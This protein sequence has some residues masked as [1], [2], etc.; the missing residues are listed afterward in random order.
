MKI[1]SVFVFLAIIALISCTS[2]NET[3][4]ESFSVAEE[5]GLGE[6]LNNIEDPLY[7]EKADDY[8]AILNQCLKDY[9]E[10]VDAN[11]SD[12]LY[13]AEAYKKMRSGI[14][15]G[16]LE[17][18]IFNDEINNILESA[19]FRIYSES[20]PVRILIHKDILK[21]YPEKK[22]L[23]YS[24][25]SH[26]IWHYYDYT[27]DEENFKSASYDEFEDLMYQIDAYFIEGEFVQYILSDVYE[28]LTYFEEYLLTCYEQKAMNGFTSIFM[29]I[30][31]I[32]LDEIYKQKN[33]CVNGEISQDEFYDIFITYGESLFD[34]NQISEEDSDW[35]KYG[36]YI[37]LNT[38]NL[39]FYKSINYIETRYTN[40]G[41]L[42]KANPKI[43][44]LNDYYT[45]YTQPYN[46]E[47]NDYRKFLFARFTE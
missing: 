30:D 11:L 39:Y 25:I 43:Q 4:K 45:I 41:E 22:T 26:E 10:L 2:T 6:T 1:K 3:V 20:D 47:M 37:T 40:F 7:T 27:V 29:G 28:N 9:F 13:F 34:E 46:E 38:F 12:D 44:E 23:L 32:V 15:E 33:R 21:L 19:E 5:L 42:F 31:H 17:F 24:M 14:N 36:K 18:V 16:V 8:T 35:I